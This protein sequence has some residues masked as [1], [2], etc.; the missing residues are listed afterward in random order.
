MAIDF[1][2]SHAERLVVATIGAGTRRSDYPKFL[3]GMSEAGAH[4]Y[5]KIVDMRFAPMEFKASD[6][7]AFGQIV[8]GWGESGSPGPTALL[9]NS[10][11]SQE[12]AGLFREYARAARPVNVF[13]DEKAARAW[14]DEVSPL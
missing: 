11:I 14:L 5:R 12:I 1:E 4:G 13:N 2:V 7:R 9:V 10:E 8:K 3:T 6:I